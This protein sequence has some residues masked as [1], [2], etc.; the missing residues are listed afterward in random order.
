VLLVKLLKLLDL[1]LQDVGVP[2]GEG[3]AALVVPGLLR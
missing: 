3:S 1:L 2:A